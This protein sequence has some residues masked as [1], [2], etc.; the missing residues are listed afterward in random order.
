MPS[1]CQTQNILLTT[2]HESF[3]KQR[4]KK[5]KKSIMKIT[6]KPRKIISIHI[7]NKKKYIE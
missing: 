1:S 5:E 6:D 3:F 4:Y 2:T 7:Q